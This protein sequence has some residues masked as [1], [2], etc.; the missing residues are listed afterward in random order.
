ADPKYSSIISG[1]PGYTIED[2]RLSNIRI[3]A[4]GGGTKEQAAL[5]PPEREAVYPE[6]TM[7]GELPAYGFFIRHVKGLTMR[8]VELS[9]LKPDQRPAF[10]MNNVAGANFIQVKA[11]LEPNVPMFVTKN[12]TDFNH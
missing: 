11:Q 8:D 5:D 4:Q 9:Y 7:F 1:I 12:V 2:V 6:P 10:V 3:Y